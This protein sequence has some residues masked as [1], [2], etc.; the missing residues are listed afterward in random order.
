MGKEK[1]ISKVKTNC[2]PFFIILSLS[3]PNRFQ[4][5]QYKA[6]LTF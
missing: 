6:V 1:H 2:V 5:A 3:Q 4:Q